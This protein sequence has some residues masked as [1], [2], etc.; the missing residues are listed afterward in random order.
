[1]ENVLCLEL[2]EILPSFQVKGNL[3]TLSFG[4]NSYFD[5]SFSQSRSKINLV[6]CTLLGDGVIQII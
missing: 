6:L 1:V 5:L 4:D 2:H 3:F